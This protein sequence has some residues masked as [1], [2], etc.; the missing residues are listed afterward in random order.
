M[1]PKSFSATLCVEARCTNCAF[2]SW[3]KNA[4]LVAKCVSE[5]WIQHFGPPI[6]VLAYEGKEF[7]GTQFKEFT[8]ANSTLLH[9]NDVRAPWQNGRTELH[10][11][12]YKRIFERA[13]WMQSP[14]G[15]AAPQRLA[16]ECNAAK[17]SGYSPLSECSEVDTVFSRT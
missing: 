14:S 3:K 4:A 1:A 17:S 8:Y 12:I 5:R 2:L 9:V 6:F 15:L 7:V 13:R 11:D 10:G 16:V